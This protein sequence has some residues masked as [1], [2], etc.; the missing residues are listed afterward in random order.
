MAVN[1]VRRGSDT[2]RA[3]DCGR[4]LHSTQDELARL[5]AVAER[6]KTAAVLAP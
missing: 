2:V 3:T 5:S 4:L 6:T 1:K